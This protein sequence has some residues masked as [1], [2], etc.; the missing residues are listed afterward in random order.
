MCQCT[1]TKRTPVCET[2]PEPLR[3]SWGMIPSPTSDE[4]LAKALDALRESVI[5]HDS[6][7]IRLAALVQKQA[8]EMRDLHQLVVHQMTKLSDA[9]ERIDALETAIALGAKRGAA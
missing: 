1:P 9:E 7:A 6:N 8:A 5:A 4:A 3:R 2:C